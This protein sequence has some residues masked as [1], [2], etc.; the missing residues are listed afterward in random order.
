MYSSSFYLRYTWRSHAREWSG[1]ENPWDIHSQN[2]LPNCLFNILYLQRVFF[3]RTFQSF[4][5][6]V[7][8]F[9]AK[10]ANCLLISGG[11]CKPIKF[12]AMCDIVTLRMIFLSFSHLRYPTWV[13][14]QQKYNGST[15]FSQVQCHKIGWT[16]ASWST[17]NRIK[18]LHISALY[19]QFSPIGSNIYLLTLTVYL[20]CMLLMSKFECRQYPFSLWRFLLLEQEKKYFKIDNI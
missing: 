4:L 1:S 7:P 5:L 20:H 19:V 9:E 17:S 8:P 12:K 16:N 6:Y 11:M 13:N 10:I 2:H 14:T 3:S 15:I 18:H